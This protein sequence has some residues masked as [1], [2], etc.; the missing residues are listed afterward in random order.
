MS[1]YYNQAD[2]QKD[3]NLNKDNAVKGKYDEKKQSLKICTTTEDIRGEG[4]NVVTSY[5]TRHKRSA[6]MK[7]ERK[8]N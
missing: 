3:E 4:C 5:V 1:T 6:V 7:K 8:T 2:L